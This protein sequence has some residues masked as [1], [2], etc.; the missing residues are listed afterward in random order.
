MNFPFL[1]SMSAD[2]AG[3]KAHRTGHVTKK[4]V[5]YVV[6]ALI[7]LAIFLFP[8]Y[9]TLKGQADWHTCAGNMNNI[10]QA[11]SL[12]MAD[13]D[14]RFPPVAEEADSRTGVPFISNGHVTTWATQVY[15]YN[16]KVNFFCPS[17]SDDEAVATG[18]R[19]DDPTTHERKTITFADSYGMFR[20]LSAASKSLIPHPENNILF[21]ETSN[22]G[23]QSSYDPAPFRAANGATTPFDA[24]VIGWDA[25][26]PAAADNDLKYA[27]VEPQK[28]SKFVTRLAFR[29]SKGG[30]SKDSVSRHGE[31]IHAI[32]ADGNL[33]NLVPG[34]ARIKSDSGVPNPFWA[35]PAIIGH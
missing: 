34:D 18:A 24:F 19:I 26:G 4:D 17:A 1:V 16:P 30:Y 7:V 3:D 6:T 14:E 21:A 29:N 12:Y 33:I 25:P 9:D 35:T 2:P 27:N 20:G 23:A 31:K 13:N 8:V 22:N 32:T 5:R 28:N 11:V 10:F 15:K